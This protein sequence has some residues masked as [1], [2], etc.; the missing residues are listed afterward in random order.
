MKGLSTDKFKIQ[1]QNL[2][3]NGVSGKDTSSL[4]NL[5]REPVKERENA[6]CVVPLE[7]RSSGISEARCAAAKWQSELRFQEDVVNAVA[8][9]AN[10]NA[11]TKS[12]LISKE[13]SNQNQSG[14]P[15]NIEFINQRQSAATLPDSQIVFG[16]QQL[17]F[18]MPETKGKNIVR[19]PKAVVEE[20]IKKWDQCLVGQ[21]LGQSADISVMLN[22]ANG[23]WGKEGRIE[24]T[25]TENELYIFKFPNERTR[26]FVLE[27][28]PWY[29]ANNPLVMRRWQPKMKLLELDKSK[30]PVWIKLMGI[31]MEYMTMQ[32]LS[33]IASAVGKPLY[34][35]RATASMST[36][37]FAKVCVEISIEDKI[38][39]DIS[40]M[41]MVRNC[42]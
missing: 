31:P 39:E 36:I 15:R 33:Y 14:L 7:L 6:A 27:S 22:M 3:G 29:M 26:D 42:L 40:V 20:G 35:D 28:G 34:V 16:G 24:V 37:A 23:L 5:A 12:L 1:H 8:L 13:I 10:G 4:H 19:I 30:I 25:K 9:K 32:G 21:F 18:F 11:V 41:M 17:R 38:M 2:V